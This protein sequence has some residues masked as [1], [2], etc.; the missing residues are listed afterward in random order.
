MCDVMYC[1]VWQAGKCLREKSI[2]GRLFK[3][4]SSSSLL[5]ASLPPRIIKSAKVIYGTCS[6]IWHKSVCL[7]SYECVCVRLYTD[8]HMGGCM[9]MY[10]RTCAHVCIVACVHPRAC[11][12]KWEK[13]DILFSASDWVWYHVSYNVKSQHL[14]SHDITWHDRVLQK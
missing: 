3:I 8:M 1:F 9:C 11:R 4:I 12:N 2:K 10:A 13:I 14:T 7:H 5:S 6:K